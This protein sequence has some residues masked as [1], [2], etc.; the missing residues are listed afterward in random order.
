[1]RPARDELG[2]SEPAFLLVI[3]IIAAVAL[4]LWL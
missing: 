1:M 3:F 2:L 4:V